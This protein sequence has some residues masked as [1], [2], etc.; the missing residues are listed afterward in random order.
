MFVRLKKSAGTVNPVVQIVESYREEGKV[1]QRVLASLGSVQGESDL[2]RLNALARNLMAKIQQERTKQKNLFENS[3]PLPLLETRPNRSV[4]KKKASDEPQVKVENLQH[5]ETVHDGFVSV[6]ERLF[7]MTGLGNIAVHRPTRMAFD[8]LRIAKILVAQRFFNPTSKHRTF[9]RQKDLGINDLKLQQIYRGMDALVRSAEL[10]QCCAFETTC[11]QGSLFKQK[12]ECLFVDVTTLYFESVSTD[13]LRNF[14]YSKDQK[15][16]CVQIVLCLI[17]NSD[18]IPIAYETF[19]GNTAE[20]STVSPIVDKLKQRFDVKRI[21]IVCDRGLASRENIEKL[22][23]LGIGYVAACKIKHLP[24]ALKLNDLSTYELFEKSQDNEVW[25]RRIQH[26]R[27]PDTDLIITWSKKRAAKDKSDRER[28]I[29]RLQDKL[30]KKQ[31]SSPKVKKL[32]SNSGYCKFVEFSGDGQWSINE[33]AEAK[34]ASWDGLHALAV[35]KSSQL[36]N[37][38]ALAQYRNLYRIEEAFRVSKSYFEIRPMFH[39]TPRRIEAH[40]LVCFISLFL[41]RYLESVL[42]S[43][44]K[45]LTPDRI[46]HALQGAHSIHFQDTITGR[47]GVMESTLSKDARE[48]FEALSLPVKRGTKLL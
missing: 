26:P 38:A 23:S 11:R 47:C 33:A 34:A 39:W 42:R 7:S 32:V 6:V 22:G 27:Y 20:V 44:K 41:E 21:T 9:Q 37:A 48:I 15:Y 24:E 8:P 17:V 16:H 10:F 4:P 31:T 36:S 45:L 29:K 14:G 1:K 40:V 19:P 30:G 2:D 12:I 5:K 46:R 13:S 18:G 43:Q 3:S 35:A 28:I 25:V